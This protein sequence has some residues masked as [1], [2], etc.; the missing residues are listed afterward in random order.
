MQPS[1]AG[2]IQIEGILKVAAGVARGELRAVHDAAD[3]RVRGGLE[4]HRAVARKSQRAGV[5]RP[6]EDV[7]GGEDARG[8]GRVIQAREDG[9]LPRVRVRER[10]DRGA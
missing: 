4:E 5:V 7:D 10:G 9:G 2:N 8:A 6:E 1:G 3:A